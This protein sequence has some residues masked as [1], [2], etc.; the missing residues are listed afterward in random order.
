MVDSLGYTTHL[1]NIPIEVFL[2]MIEG[3]IKKLIRKYGHKNCGLMHEEL[4]EKI[5]TTVTTKKTHIF[6]LMDEYGQQKLNREWRSKKNEFFKKLFE[7]EEFI[8]VCY[9]LKEK[10]NQ[11]LQKL[12]LK[13]IEF[14]KEKD[15]RRST[16]GNNPE[17]S[18]CRQ[19]N[20]WIET[21]KASFTR[22]FLK[23][24]SKSNI[25]TVKKY[26]ITKKHPGGHDPLLTYRNSKLDCSK[27][28]S[29]S[30]SH[31]QIPLQKAHP[32]NLHLPTAPAVRKESQGIGGK[33]IPGG[34]RGTEKE[35]S[36]AKILPKTEPA[37]SDSLISPV[38]KTKV[39]GTPNG[40]RT[41][42]NAKGTGP[43]VN[44]QAPTVKPTEATDTQAQSHEQLPE[45]TISISHTDSSAAKVLNPP[46]SVIIG[47][48]TG[49]TASTTSDTSGATHSTENVQSSLSS[50]LSLV[51]S[52]PQ[53]PPVDLGTANNSKEPTPD[54][55]I[56]SPD[57]DIPPTTALDPG[58]A[59]VPEAASNSSASGTS[60][61][62]V[63]TTTDS[64]AGSPPAHDSLL[65]TVPSQSTTT[66]VSVIGTQP[67]SIV[68]GNAITTKESENSKAPIKTISDPHYLT[69]VSTKKQDDSI[70]QSI[71]AQ[72]PGSPVD[73]SHDP[74]IPAP[75]G[76]AIQLP[77]LS[78]GMSPDVSSAVHSVVNNPDSPNIGVSQ[79]DAPPHSK[80]TTLDSNTPLQ[81]VTY[82]SEK[83]SIAPTEFPPLMNI[84]PTTLIL[85]ATLTILFLLYK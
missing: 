21:E 38:S 10:G 22:E 20:V 18:V 60:S 80:G 49:V 56:K 83:P 44:A 39:H 53:L 16:I 54:P 8:N 65:I 72:F 52:Q 7:E 50:D 82:P 35:K 58:L 15:L 5:Q 23:I 19:Y 12:K 57:S 68:T 6:K 42:L 78:P 61:T 2:D 69:S 71:G 66:A 76:T 31:P 24:V 64:T 77:T 43:P 28:K 33:S 4:C 3:D 41:D 14:C 32:D 13:H 51:Q 59:S 25:Q 84:I 79:R 74:Q 85:L 40:K 73:P 55:A 36:D 9:P 27:Y 81:N 75:P 1:R 30:S 17:Y 46:A 63:S 48:D 67:V 26:F 37:A 62:M 70:A 11:N 45:P 34:E 29:P 47:K